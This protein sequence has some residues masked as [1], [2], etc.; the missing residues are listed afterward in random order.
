M[1]GCQDVRG[2]VDIFSCMARLTN[3]TLALVQAC[4]AVLW[5][6]RGVETADAI[7]SEVQ[8]WTAPYCN[9]RQAVQWIK[10]EIRLVDPA[11][12]PALGIKTW[13]RWNSYF[14][15]PDQDYEKQKSELYLAICAGAIPLF[16]RP[17]IGA[18]VVKEAGDSSF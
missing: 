4:R 16:G 15:A 18:P 12:E 2:E 6:Q 3:R 13:G 5:R 8:G 7:F 10:D 9:L 1:L 14:V 17:G 11:Y